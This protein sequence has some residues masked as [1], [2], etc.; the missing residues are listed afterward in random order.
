MT[1]TETN[2]HWRLSADIWKV[3]GRRLERRTSWD[4][5]ESSGTKE[6]RGKE[7]HANS[8]ATASTHCA[9]PQ[10]KR[11][12]MLL[13]I[14]YLS[15]FS[16]LQPLGCAMQLPPPKLQLL[17]TKWIITTAF[18]RANPGKSHSA[19]VHY[20][21]LQPAGNWVGIFRP[22]EGPGTRARDRMSWLDNDQITWPVTWYQRYFE[23]HVSKISAVK[24]ELCA[25]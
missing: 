11:A 18:K 5:G 13:M 9:I 4:F 2:E 17:A 22:F 24:C 23:G 7:V 14:L 19:P 8:Q 25:L 16:V 21:S 3:K 20:Q 10:R 6:V 12:N 1:K 15:T